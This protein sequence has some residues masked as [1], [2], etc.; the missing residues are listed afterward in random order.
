MIVLSAFR[1]IRDVV[2]EAPELQRKLP[3][4]RGE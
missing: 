3:P 2:R 1:F 4:H